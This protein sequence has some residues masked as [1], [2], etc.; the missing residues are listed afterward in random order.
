MPSCAWPAKRPFPRSPFGF[1][2]WW[3]VEVAR[4]RAVGRGFRCLRG[5]GSNMNDAPTRDHDALLEDWSQ[6]I[7]PLEI[8]FPVPVLFV[9]TLQFP[10]PSPNHQIS[11]SNLKKGSD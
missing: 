7:A 11:V 9:H 8:N 4:R 10:I 6:P 1:V 5:P 3:I 2:S